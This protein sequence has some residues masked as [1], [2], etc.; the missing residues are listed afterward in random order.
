MK[1]TVGMSMILFQINIFYYQLR[2]APMSHDNNFLMG[3]SM[4]LLLYMFV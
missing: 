4:T 2:V 1:R 3:V